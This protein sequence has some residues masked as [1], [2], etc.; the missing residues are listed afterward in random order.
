MFITPRESQNFYTYFLRN[1]YTSEILYCG[2]DKLPDIFNF[3]HLRKHS[4]FDISVPYLIELRTNHPFLVHAKNKQ[5]ELL[6]VECAGKR[7]PFNWMEI[8][9]KTKQ[10][11]DDDSGQIFKSQQEICKIMGLNQGQLSK[12][13]A[14]APG[15]R[16][17]K[18]HRF[19]YV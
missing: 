17:V 2:V 4:Q 6:K 11:K 5:S 8:E 18:G 1:P 3:T 19:S 14:R 13:L 9:H 10:I 16:T 7:P 15:Y 12:H